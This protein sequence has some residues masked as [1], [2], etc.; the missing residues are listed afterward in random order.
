MLPFSHNIFHKVLCD[1]VRLC[2]C[3]FSSRMNA[4]L[5]WH[6]LDDESGLDNNQVMQHK[7]DTYAGPHLNNGWKIGLTPLIS[8]T[9]SRNLLS[10]FL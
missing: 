8:C 6:G 4:P 10:F 3:Y 2:W 1:P 9:V 5:R 7:H